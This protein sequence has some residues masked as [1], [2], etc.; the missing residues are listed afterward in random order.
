MTTAKAQRFLLE[1]LGRGSTVLLSLHLALPSLPPWA[2]GVDADG[3]AVLLVGRHGLGAGVAADE[4]LAMVLGVLQAGEVPDGVHAIAYAPRASAAIAEILG[5][6][7]DEVLLDGPRGS[8]KTQAVPGALAGLAELHVRAGAAAPLRVLWLHDSLTNAAVKTGRSLEHPLWGGL[9]SLRDDRRVAVL[10][11]AGVELVVADFVGTRDEASAERL[12]AECHVLAA[13]ELVP[14]LDEAGGIEERKYELGSSSRRLPTRRRVTMATTNPGDVDTW[15]F[16]R[17]IE[18]GGRPG[19]VRC[20]VPA[21]DRLTPTEIAALRDV[22]RDS[23]DL[24]ARLARGEWSGLKLGEMVAEGYDGA[25]HVAPGPLVP[26]AD[27]VLAIGWDG[28]HSPSAVIGQ[29]V[30]GQVRVFAGL[31]DLKVGVL[32][33]IEDQATRGSCSGRPGPGA[34][35]RGAR[36]CT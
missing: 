2:D 10:T 35:R 26:S 25:V 28:G 6:T 24:E 14:T 33:L 16:K 32:E 36:W 20:E 29:M 8:G 21:T 17:W 31:N 1:R 22:F 5:G 34:V 13:E 4:A 30:G 18:G 27:H 9:W 12:R 3:Q 7:P 19:C 23:P 15:P 11:V